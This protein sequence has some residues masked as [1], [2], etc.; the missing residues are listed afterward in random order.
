MKF[1]LGPWQYM[2]RVYSYIAGG[3]VLTSP[4]TYA[5]AANGL[6]QAIVCTPLF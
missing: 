3:L 5:D 1:D 6:Y 2:L 4:G